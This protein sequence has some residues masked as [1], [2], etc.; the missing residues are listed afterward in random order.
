MRRLINRDRKEFLGNDDDILDKYTVEY[1]DGKAPAAV[2]APATPPPPPS[3][4]TA[5]K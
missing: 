2:D 1:G 5:S 3:G 4:P